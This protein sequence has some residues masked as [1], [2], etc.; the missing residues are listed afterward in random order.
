LLVKKVCLGVCQGSI[1][2]KSMNRI[3]NSSMIQIISPMGS[4]WRGKLWSNTLLK[5]K[6]DQYFLRKV[7]NRYPSFFLRPYIED[8]TSKLRY[9]F[10]SDKVH[11]QFEN[12]LSSERALGLVDKDAY[13]T[14]Q[15]GI[16]QDLFQSGDK[17][18]VVIESVPYDAS[19][20]SEV[21]YGCSQIIS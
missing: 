9:D 8:Y 14:L 19:N 2:Q 13:N 3:E 7:E 21:I 5:V 12:C 20:T 6:V 10:D 15:V 18:R 4:I 17:F 1:M 16:H 11:F